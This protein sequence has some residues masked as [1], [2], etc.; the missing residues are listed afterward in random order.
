MKASKRTWIRGNL[1]LDEALRYAKRRGADIGPK[2]RTGE[3]R[4][5]H[6]AINGGRPVIAHG[7]RKDTPRVVMKFVNRLPDTA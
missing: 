3:V 1:N 6:P 7:G 5:S 2:R 4:L